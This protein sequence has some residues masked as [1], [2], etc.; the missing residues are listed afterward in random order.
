M[1]ALPMHAK[2]VHIRST[3]ARA[4]THTHTHRLAI[5]CNGAKHMLQVVSWFVREQVIAF[6][7]AYICCDTHTHTHT[8]TCYII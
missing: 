1:H 6:V 3:R 4:H 2:I 7:Y 5:V 8:H